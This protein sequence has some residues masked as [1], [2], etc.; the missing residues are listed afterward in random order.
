MWYPNQTEIAKFRCQENGQVFDIRKDTKI[1]GRAGR[2]SKRQLAQKERM[3]ETI[4]KFR[5]AMTK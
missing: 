3:K 1:G 2:V 5:Q 4:E